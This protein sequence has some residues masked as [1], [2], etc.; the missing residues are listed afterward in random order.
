[1][2]DGKPAG[3]RLARQLGLADAVVLGLGSMLGAGVFASFGPAAAA[4]DPASKQV[5]LVNSPTCIVE[6]GEGCSPD[7]W[8]WDGKTW[9]LHPS[10]AVIAASQSGFLFADTKRGRLVMLDG[11]F[12]TLSGVSRVWDG[13]NWSAL[14]ARPLNEVT[15]AGPAYDDGAVFLVAFG[16]DRRSTA[17]TTS[18]I[19]I[20][21][22]RRS[23]RCRSRWS[24]Y[25]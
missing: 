14:S 19:H 20:R 11:G 4:F 5:V 10:S 2:T 3:P 7:T 17:D 13:V 8:S 15:V 23:T 9:T 21:R 6:P 22:C 12:W 18:L 24:P 1:M 16:S 25:L